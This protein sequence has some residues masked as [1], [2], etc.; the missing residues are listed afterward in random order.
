MILPINLQFTL[1]WIKY[2][3]LGGVFALFCEIVIVSYNSKTI[4][5]LFC[6]LP[7]LSPFNKRHLYQLTHTELRSSVFCQR[8]HQIINNS[9]KKGTFPWTS[10]Y[11]LSRC[12]GPGFSVQIPS[13]EVFGCLGFDFLRIFRLNLQIPFHKLSQSLNQHATSTNRPGVSKNP[14]ACSSASSFCFSK[15]LA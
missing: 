14:S 6:K 9:K 8:Y 11:L 10:K 1:S 4:H 7:F 13:Q 5:T 2:P 3:F 12:L 15:Y